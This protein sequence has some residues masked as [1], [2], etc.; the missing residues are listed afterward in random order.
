MLYTFNSLLLAGILLVLMLLALLLGFKAGSRTQGERATE[1]Y[2]GH[3]DT[4]QTSM[5]GILALLLGF[6]FS[7]ALQRF[8]SR[9]EALV[10]EANAIGTTL[11]RASL[12][13]PDLQPE[14]RQLL[15]RY[16]G[17]RVAGADLPLAREMERNLLLQQAEGVQTSLWGLAVRASGIDDSPVRTGLFVQALNEMFDAFV[18]RNAELDRHVPEPVELVLY[19][20]YMITAAVLGF[21]AGLSRYRPSLVTHVMIMLIVLINLMITDLDHPRS[22]IIRIDQTAL[23]SLADQV[24]LLPVTP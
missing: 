8:E 10:E 7:L 4:L 23:R 22:G 9:S 1:R 14:A 5:L 21:N 6:T 18:K 15:G 3:I 20:T 12:L 19:L 13:S 24:S 11:L 17:L 16:L 2:L